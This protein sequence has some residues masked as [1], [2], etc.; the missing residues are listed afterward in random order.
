MKLEIKEDLIRVFEKFC[1]ICGKEE[2]DAFSITKH[3][4]IPQT[5]KPK[6]N[7]LIPLCRSCHDKIHKTDKSL[8]NSFAFKMLQQ[9]KRLVNLT[10]HMRL[11]P[12]YEATIKDIAK[13]KKRKNG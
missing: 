8:L 5:Y 6:S 12:T 11:R 13:I 7:V 2:K 4:A 1:F 9:I 3:H 10:E